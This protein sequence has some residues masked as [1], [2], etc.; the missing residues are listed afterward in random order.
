MHHTTNQ[1]KSNMNRLTRILSSFTVVAVLLAAFSI[2][3]AAQDIPGFRAPTELLLETSTGT[4]LNPDLTLY[5]PDDLAEMR[6][7]TSFQWIDLGAPKYKLVFTEVATGIKHTRTV[8][9]AACNGV[10]CS[11][12]PHQ[13]GFFAEIKDGMVLTWQVIAVMPNYKIKSAVRTLTVNEV[14]SPPLVG[15]ANGATISYHG[16]LSWTNANAINDYVRVVMIDAQTGEKALNQFFDSAACGA[17]CSITPR[18]LTNKLI[19]G[20]TYKWYVMGVGFAGEKA[21][22]EVRTVVIQ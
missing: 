4:R 18:Y 5:A 8:N 20:R 10:N 12:I 11:V 19:P 14:M 3:A 6:T 1:R 7:Y 22:S 16:A 21:K 15:P 13:S 17:D 9:S 2:T